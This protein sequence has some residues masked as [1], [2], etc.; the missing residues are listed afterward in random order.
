MR[1]GPASGRFLPAPVADSAPLLH[2]SEA[3]RAGKVLA[4]IAAEKRKA[5]RAAY[6]KAHCAALLASLDRT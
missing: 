5:K 6:V 2:V 1:R 3:S 4:A